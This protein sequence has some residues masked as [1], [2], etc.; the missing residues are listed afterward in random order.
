[1]NTTKASV[2]RKGNLNPMWG[3]KHT[4]ETKEKISNSQKA[5]YN[6]IRK[7]IKEQSIIDYG[8]DSPESRKRVLAHLLDNNDLKFDNMKQVADFLAIMIGKDRIQEII[9]SQVDKLIAESYKVGNDKK[10]HNPC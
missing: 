1:M 8:D 4:P 7:A 10:G 6:A 5:R 2:E 9:R 3:R